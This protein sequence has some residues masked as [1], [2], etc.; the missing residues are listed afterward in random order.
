MTTLE[1]TDDEIGTLI[2][3]VGEWM[4][5]S[6]L[7]DQEWLRRQDEGADLDMDLREALNRKDGWDD[8]PNEV[9]PEA[10]AKFIQASIDV[11]EQNKGSSGA[12]QRRE[13]QVKRMMKG[14]ATPTDPD[15]WPLNDPADW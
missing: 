14:T 5:Q 1:L 6:G 4:E 2:E 9:V 12:A 11:R 8:R 3:A 15:T 10:A 7:S 13:E